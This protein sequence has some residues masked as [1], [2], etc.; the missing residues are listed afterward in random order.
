M[1][2]FEP[3]IV[4]ILCKS[5]FSRAGADKLSFRPLLISVVLFKK[6]RFQIRDLDRLLHQIRCGHRFGRARRWGNLTLRNL[7][8]RAR[9]CHQRF[10]FRFELLYTLLGSLHLTACGRLLHSRHRRLGAA[11]FVG[12]AAAV[13]IRLRERV[14]AAGS[15]RALRVDQHHIHDVMRRRETLRIQHREADA[16][17]Q[18]QMDADR[19]DGRGLHRDGN[20]Q[21]TLN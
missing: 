16:Q 6:L 7:G 2:D 4:D 20:G 21:R 13:E 14:G 19:G 11:L 12:I 10:H 15:R 8:R 1:F 17:H 3:P 5:I 18:K 9:L